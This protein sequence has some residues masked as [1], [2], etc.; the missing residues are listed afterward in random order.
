M[1]D[2]SS[3]PVQAA[4]TPIIPTTSEKHTPAWLIIIL[5][6]LFWPLALLLIYTDRKYHSWISHLLVSIGIIAII[7]NVSIM[8]FIIPQL[9]LLYKS[10]ELSYSPLPFY[11]I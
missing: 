1:N 4:A 10:L 5:L 2:N 3:E 8:L 6:L 7:L 9:T 11:L